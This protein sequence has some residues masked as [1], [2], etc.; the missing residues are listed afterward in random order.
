MWVKCVGLHLLIS[1][2]SD[3]F[4]VVFLTSAS[5]LIFMT[6]IQKDQWQHHISKVSV[7]FLSAEL[8]SHSFCLEF[9]VELM[10]FFTS[11]VL[12][13][14][15][16]QLFPDGIKAGVKIGSTPVNPHYLDRAIKKL[17][18]LKISSIRS[19]W[20]FINKFS[21]FLSVCH[22][23]VSYG[24]FFKSVL[25]ICFTLVLMTSFNLTEFSHLCV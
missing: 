17:F 15:K 13:W 23:K 1:D 2:N 12:K 16:E 19:V 8:A 14:F 21:C 25:S 9:A 24:L 3:F 6:E 4:P 7:S 5:F 18:L 22:Y 10:E 11:Q 20:S